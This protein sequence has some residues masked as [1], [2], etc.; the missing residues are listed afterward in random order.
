MKFVC[1]E[2]TLGALLQCKCTV[3]NK[4]IKVAQ[5]MPCATFI[6]SSK[7][8]HDQGVK[9]RPIFLSIAMLSPL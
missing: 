2:K 3:E 1:K 8:Q 6:K 4:I 7:Q 9:P 5:D